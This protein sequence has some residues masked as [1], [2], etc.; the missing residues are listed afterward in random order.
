MPLFPPSIRS[1]EHTRPHE[2]QKAQLWIALPV[3]ILVDFTIWLS[4]P[5]LHI[6]HQRVCV[7]VCL[8]WNGG[9]SA[10]IQLSLWTRRRNLRP[11]NTDQSPR[12][13]R[14][15]GGTG[16]GGGVQERRRGCPRNVFKTNEGRINQHLIKIQSGGS[17]RHWIYS[18]AKPNI[19]NWFL[20]SL[21]VHTRRMMDMSANR[22]ARM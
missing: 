7:C 8:W 22:G 9:T 11:A 13:S 5:D 6:S 18:T 3:K 20:L 21:C 4:V 10:P 1:H 2:E 19:S 15:H 12:I 17:I 14:D 16:W